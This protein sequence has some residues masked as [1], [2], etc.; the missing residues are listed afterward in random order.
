MRAFLLAVNS[1]QVV[2]QGLDGRHLHMLPHPHVRQN[3]TNSVLAILLQIR[4][5][6]S[7]QCPTQT[8]VAEWVQSLQHPGYELVEDPFLDLLGD[9]PYDL[10]QLV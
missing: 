4:A 2:N 9:P 6:E 8:G 10:Q 3:V 7:P 5:D 1:L